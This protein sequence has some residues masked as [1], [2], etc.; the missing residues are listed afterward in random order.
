[1]AEKTQE[2]DLVSQRKIK[3]LAMQVNMTQWVFT[4]AANS[5]IFQV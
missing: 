4:R 5:T 1:M 2:A 3:D